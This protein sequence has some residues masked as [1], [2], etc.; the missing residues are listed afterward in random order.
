MPSLV[1][2]YNAD[3]GLFST[4]VDIAHK[5]F[6]PR[7]YACK[8]CHLT[9][10]YFTGRKDWT[11]FLAELEVKLEFL[12]RDELEAKYGLTDISLPVILFKHNNRLDTWISTEEINRCQSLEVL[13]VL[14]NHRLHQS[15]TSVPK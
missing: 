12:H 11:E 2:V 7:T 10:S 1:F 14:I 15:Q 9:H 13:K 8:L 6:S 4:L 5:I 3:S